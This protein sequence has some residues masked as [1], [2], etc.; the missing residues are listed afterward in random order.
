MDISHITPEDLSRLSAAELEEYISL[1]TDEGMKY[2]AVYKLAIAYSNMQ[3]MEGLNERKAQYMQYAQAKGDPQLLAIAYRLSG[4][5]NRRIGNLHQALDDFSTS[6]KY[7]SETDRLNLKANILEALGTVYVQLGMHQEALEKFLETYKINSLGTN[8]EMTAVAAFNVAL[9]LHLFNRYAD[10]APYLEEAMEGA[11]ELKNMQLEVNTWI[12]L[13]LA[14]KGMNRYEDALQSL[15][16][17]MALS[18]QLGAGPFISSAAS[19][20]GMILTEMGQYNEAKEYLDKA[21]NLAE[22]MGDPSHLKDIH[23]LFFNMYKAQE[24]YK[25]ALEHYIKER[26][27]DQQIRNE[28]TL[29]KAHR[30]ESQLEL[31]RKENEIAIERAQHAQELAN[32][33]LQTLG[34]IA[35]EMAHEIQ[36]PL[37]FVN[38][39]SDLNLEL[40]EELIEFLDKND[41]EEVRAINSDMQ[42]N[43]KK[44]RE[45]GIR[46]AKIVDEL[47]TQANMAKAGELEVDTTNSHDFSSRD[48]Q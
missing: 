29:Q 3:N 18:E 34:K 13:G 23:G 48:N 17:A 14:Q 2:D 10:M 44:I 37:Q 4:L 7:I 32:A 31:E 16:K 24:N 35:S 19:N 28:A 30:L 47:Q 46:I 15:R 6:L 26:E 5:A 1:A 9:T 40:N 11:K 45:H 27:L 21:L 38:N 39:F 20:M 42:E 33:R 8:K 12:Y 22:R 41:L 36:N 25:N 43:N